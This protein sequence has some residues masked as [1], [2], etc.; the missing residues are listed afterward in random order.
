MSGVVPRMGGS[1]GELGM[2]MSRVPLVGLGS[3]L[4]LGGSGLLLGF[5]LC[6]VL[7]RS[8]YGVGAKMPSSSSAAM[9]SC[10][11]DMTAS[12]RGYVPSTSWRMSTYAPYSRS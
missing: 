3:D 2:L 6:S 1:E 5:L 10:S 7:E 9:M 11:P 12:W 4:V 8:G